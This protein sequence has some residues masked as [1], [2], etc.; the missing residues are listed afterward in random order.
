LVSLVITGWTWPWRQ[1][2]DAAGIGGGYVSSE[3]HDDKEND[4][5]TPDNG[6]K[7][8]YRVWKDIDVSDDAQIEKFLGVLGEKVFNH[9]AMRVFVDREPEPDTAQASF[10]A[11][12]RQTTHLFFVPIVVE[13]ED[14]AQGES[15]KEE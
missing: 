15:D 12:L 2:L 13:K 7:R 5:A 4:A 8:Y 3:A 1:Q 10:L 14:D 6:N 11:T 9:L